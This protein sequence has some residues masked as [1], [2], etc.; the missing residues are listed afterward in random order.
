MYLIFPFTNIE[1]LFMQ[2]VIFKETKRT[3]QGID[4]KSNNNTWT[5]FKH[6]EERAPQPKIS[7]I[8]KRA[9]WNHKQ[10]HSTAE[11]VTGTTHIQHTKIKIIRNQSGKVLF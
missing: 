1:I 9:R 2:Y 5:I 8:I 3:M 11:P 10:T 6:V 7:G 4:G